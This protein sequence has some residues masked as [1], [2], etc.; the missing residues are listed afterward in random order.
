MWH[1]ISNN[2]AFF[3]LEGDLNGGSNICYLISKEYVNSIS[4]CQESVVTSSS[5]T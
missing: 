2:F 5:I 1:Q 3:L 4:K